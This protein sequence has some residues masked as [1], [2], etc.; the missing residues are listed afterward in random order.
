M[1][2]W[3]KLLWFPA[4]LHI[5]YSCFTCVVHLVQSMCLLYFEYYILVHV[6]M[7]IIHVLTVAITEPIYHGQDGRD[8]LQRKVNPVLIN[9][10][11]KL[12]KQKPEDPLV[13][14]CKHAWYTNSVHVHVHV[15]EHACQ[16]SRSDYLEF[17]VTCVYK[18]LT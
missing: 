1:D 14:T 6:I 18:S 17:I 3:V 4:L 5:H 13:S 8:Y 7:A 15:W 2:L 11:T 12:C 16:V 9:G 10:L